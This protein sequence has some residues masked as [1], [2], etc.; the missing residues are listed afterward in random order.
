M[1]IG[2]TGGIA[3]GKSSVSKLLVSLG[4]ILIDADQI[5]REVMLP[6]H[7]VLAAVAKQFG[8]VV[9]LEDGSLNRKKLGELVFNHPDQLQALNQIT[10][11]AIRQEMRD[12]K[13][14]FEVQ[15]PG[16][17][18][19]SDIPLLYES[20]LEDGYEQIML[21]YVPRKIQLERLMKRDG[22]DKDQA[23]RRLE[24]QMDIEE[25]KQKADIIIDNSGDFEDTKKQILAFWRDA[26]LS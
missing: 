3:S 24:A 10:H 17:L 2:L 22:L 16:R 11:P 12:R 15:F 13:H 8:Q 4:A 7:P 26:G 1:N 19:V 25:K 14:K 5:A 6:G 21:V 9:L 20:G 18:I 23:I